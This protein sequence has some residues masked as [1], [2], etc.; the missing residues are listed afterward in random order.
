VPSGAST[1]EHEAVELRDGD[2]SRFNGRGVLT[3]VNNV[4][5]PIRDLLLWR[6]GDDQDGVD[7]AMNGM[8]GTDNKSYL[9]ANAILAVSMALLKASAA[10]QGIPLYRR[11]ASLTGVFQP[12]ETPAPMFNVLNGGAHAEGSTD[13]QEFMF[14]PVGVDSVSQAIRA[15]SEIYHSLRRLL[16]EDG[17]STAVGDEGGFAPPGLTT[18]G[19]L[20]YMM[21]AIEAAGYRPGDQVALALDP[22][23]SEFATRGADGAS[24]YE[25]KRVGQTLSTEE[26]IEEYRSLAADYPIVSIE[27]GLAEDDWDGW[28]DL[29]AALGD[30]VQLVGDDL[31][32]TQTRYLE[33]G[34]KTG[35]G[36]AILI[37]VNQVGTVTETLE[38]MRTAR[39]A[40]WNA[41]V[42]HRSGETED[43]TIADLAVGAR[44]GQIK[45]G[46]PARSDRVAKYNRLL[47]IEDELEHRAV[48]AGPSLFRG[49]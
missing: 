42:S 4:N 37:K 8:D 38:A 31:F 45:T 17:V 18:R 43:T 33:E 2:R 21:K 3:A 25:L 29:T 16:H 47:N 12:V 15:A 20:D 36:N 7:R 41:V 19:A 11:I 24:R 49:R 6:D 32:V 39:E 27:D 5:G 30:R 40:G 35:A 1:G 13:F 10:S 9:G 22:A 14:M 34:I 46:A 23:A 44:S 26:M 48:Y 28:R